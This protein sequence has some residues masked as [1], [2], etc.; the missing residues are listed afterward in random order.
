MVEHKQRECSSCF[1]ACH[2]LCPLQWATGC[3]SHHL[4]KRIAS[5]DFSLS[6]ALHL[7]R[8]W[9][10]NGICHYLTKTIFSP[11]PPLTHAHTH[12]HLSTPAFG[13]VCSCDWHRPALLSCQEVAMETLS[14]PDRRVACGHVAMP[15]VQFRNRHMTQN[16]QKVKINISRLFSPPLA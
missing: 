16:I 9:C 6:K 3:G 13:N 5:F 15:T 8:Q 7:E 14:V 4:T 2:S 12:T 10:E 1:S 11:Q